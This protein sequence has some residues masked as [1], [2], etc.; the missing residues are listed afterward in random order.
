MELF[1]LASPKTMENSSCAV[2][3]IESLRNQ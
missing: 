1:S 3:S 2:W